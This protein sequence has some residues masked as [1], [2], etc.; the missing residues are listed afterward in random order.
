MF[1]YRHRNLI[2][3]CKKRYIFTSQRF[4][5]DLCPHHLVILKC[6][7][8]KKM[9]LVSQNAQFPLLINMMAQ[10]ITSNKAIKRVKIQNFI[11]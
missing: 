4:T 5:V 7:F 3:K 2:V 1:F 8:P 11:K 10:H 6:T 9:V